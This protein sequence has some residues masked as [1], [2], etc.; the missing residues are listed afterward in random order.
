[1]HHGDKGR[2]RCQRH[3]DKAALPHRRNEARLEIGFITRKGTASGI[4]LSFEGLDARRHDFLPYPVELDLGAIMR[5]QHE[6]PINDVSFRPKIYLALHKIVGAPSV[7]QATQSNPYEQNQKER[8][9]SSDWRII[10]RN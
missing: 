6:N 7:H 9:L 3:G 4:S 10:H 2:A 1:M 8:D 5:P